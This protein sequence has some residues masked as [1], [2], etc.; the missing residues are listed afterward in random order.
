MD[1]LNIALVG[2]GRRGA[3]AH[4]PV[5]AKMSEVFNL[6][7][8]CDRDSETSNRYATEYG[9][10]AYSNIFD[11][12][13]NER[14][15]IA[16]VVV[17]GDGHHGVCWY[18]MEHGI[19]ILVETPIAITLPLA[20]LMLETSRRNKVKLEV[21]ENYY[22]VPLE[23]LKAQ[24]I[25]EG[26]IGSVSRIHRIFR[27][28][29]YHGMSILRLRAGGNPTSVWGLTHTTEVIPHTDRMKRHHTQENWTISVLNFDNN[30]LAVMAY[31]NVIHARSLGRGQSGLFQ[32]DG[33]EGTIVDD[34]VYLVLPD[35]LEIGARGVAYTPKRISEKV[36]GIEV[37]QAIELELPEGKLV[38]ENPYKQ[39]GI[40]EGQVSV[41]DELWSLAGAVKEN[42][43]PDYG[44]AA[45]RLD[46][47]MN[48]G[49]HESSVKNRQTVTF[50][51]SSPTEWEQQTHERFADKYGCDPFDVEKITSIF[52][53]RV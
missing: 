42:G 5:I 23:R 29:G 51:L 27:E 15:D 4:L 31:S 28:G 32:V 39:F 12:V 36:D 6:V 7:A 14:L 41:A 22:R 26:H 30:V 21:A 8:I 18:L 49:Q 45:G 47:E 1:K 38:W 16:D 50:P 48:I 25:A 19:N 43:E 34:V 20:D 35:E 2:A 10:K 37:L 53:G 17:P 44:A 46:Q 11:L 40:T 13:S 9:C 33:T 52:F 3:G 24:V